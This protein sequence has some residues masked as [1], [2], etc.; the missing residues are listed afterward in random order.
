MA[1]KN[2]FVDNFGELSIDLLQNIAEILTLRLPEGP[3]SC[4]L[5]LNFYFS[6]KLIFKIESLLRNG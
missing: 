6:T 1:T 3:G 4:D 2:P 5:K